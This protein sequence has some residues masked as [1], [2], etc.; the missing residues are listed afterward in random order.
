MAMRRIDSFPDAKEAALS[1]ILNG[2]LNKVVWDDCQ[3]IWDSRDSL[4]GNA[5]NEEV[6]IFG[7]K[8]KVLTP[9]NKLFQFHLRHCLDLTP[10]PKY[11]LNAVMQET[12][13][14]PTNERDFGQ[15]DLSAEDDRSFFE[16]RVLGLTEQAKAQ[17]LDQTMRSFLSMAVT[18]GHHKH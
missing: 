7:A 13:G 10:Q 6:A 3:F 5:S 17:G 15:L 14:G 1:F 8:G 12:P 2:T 4:I 18:N 11:R 9:E 16:S